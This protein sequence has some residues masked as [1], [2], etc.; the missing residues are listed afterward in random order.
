MICWRNTT[1]GCLEGQRGAQ[2]GFTVVAG[3]VHVAGGKLLSLL[4]QLSCSQRSSFECHIL[5]ASLG[6]SCSP[7]V[8]VGGRPLRLQGVFAAKLLV[9]M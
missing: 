7:A 3:L 5:C 2:G 9:I 4:L 6:L 1:A 8:A